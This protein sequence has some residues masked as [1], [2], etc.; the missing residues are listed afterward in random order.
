MP[1][2]AQ[3]ELLFERL[4]YKPN[5]TQLKIH[6]SPSRIKLVT[7]GERSGK[8]TVGANELTSRCFE[9]QLYWLV[10]AEYDAT[11][12]EF[13]YICENLTKLEIP[14][15]ATKRV[16]PGEIDAGIFKILTK[17]ARDPRKLMMQAPDGIL[18]CEA[19]QVD[20]ESFLRVRGRIAEK[21]GWMMMTGTL[22]GSLGWY[23]ELFTRWQMPNEEE[24][25]AFGMPTWTNTAIF[26]GGEKDPEI[27]ALKSAS[28]KE[29]FNERYGGI[30]CPPAGRVFSE[31]SNAFHTGVGEAYN[32]D[33][34]QPVYLWIDPGYA[35]VYAVEVAQKRGDDIYIVDEIYE[36]GLVTS[37]IIKVCKQKPWWNKVT[38]GAV[39]VAGTQHQAMPAVSE[40]WLK[41]AGLRLRSRKIKIQ[42][43]IE[44]VKSY[45]NIN[46]ITGR[47]LLHINTRCKGLISEMG[48]CAN[49]ITN[50]TSVYRW[51]QDRSG[52]VIGEEPEDRDNHASKALAYGLI[53]LC[54]YSIAQLSRPKIRFW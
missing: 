32:F 5:P 28:S 52:A 42:D 13:E 40:I 41:E 15:S 1:N 36:R 38:G 50:Q 24:A 21:R 11:K 6:Q 39:D 27:L 7:G 30:P 51:R 4:G 10:G 9:G 20:Y 46:P 34:L 18:V 37:D 35:S 29:W 16:D 25:Q 47:P 3:R 22:E 17:S 14:Y 8:S 53:D 33:P 45:L 31:F 19:A 12:A 49:P 48:G 44:R 43:G 26:P 54:G 2:D 23:P